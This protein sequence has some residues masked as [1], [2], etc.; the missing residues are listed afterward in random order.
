MLS[1]TEKEFLEGTKETSP[2]YSIVL[3]GRIERKVQALEEQLRTLAGHPSFQNQILSTVTRIR[4]QITEN[5]DPTYN[6][7]VNALNA[8][9]S[10]RVTSGPGGTRTQMGSSLTTCLLY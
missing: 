2:H 4:D 8:E 9:G 10:Q 6:L 5:C 3:K 7:S 1:K